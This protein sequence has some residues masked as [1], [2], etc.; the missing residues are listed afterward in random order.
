MILR[1]CRVGPNEVIVAERYFEK[2]N[3]IFCLKNAILPQKRV[4]E[5]E[6]DA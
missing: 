6:K 3:L 1:L 5:G 4:I 2:K